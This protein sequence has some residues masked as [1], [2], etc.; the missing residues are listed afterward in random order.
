[1]KYD[2]DIHPRKSLRLKEYDY[3]RLGAY[4]ITICTYEKECIFG[5][6]EN[7]R[8]SLNQFGKIVLEFWNNLPGRYANIESDSFVI[9]PNHIHGIVKIVD[10]VGIIPELLHNNK[11]KNVGAIHELPLQTANTN[12]KTKRRRMLIPKVVGYFKMNSSKQINTI[13]NSTGIPVWQRNYYEH[14]IRNE[15][16]LNKIREYIHNNPI[17][18]HLDRE[19]QERIGNDQLEDEI[20]EHIKSAL[21]ISKT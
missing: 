1:M 5:K 15:N 4:F 16:K 8:M 12:Q 10:T 7:E 3:S 14:I 20:F 17:R 6:V 19:N 9:M 21:P 13:R 2:S 18:W 11:T